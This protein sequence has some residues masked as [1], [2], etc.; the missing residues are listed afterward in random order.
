MKKELP[1][2]GLFVHEC[3][4]LIL[5]NHGPFPHICQGPGSGWCAIGMILGM[6]LGM[7]LGPH[8]WVMLF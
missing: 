3:I 7:R 4:N 2:Q 6:I 8:I 5:D 1:S